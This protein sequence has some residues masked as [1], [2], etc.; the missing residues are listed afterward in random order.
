MKD[1]Y[2]IE[3]I[4]ADKLTHLLDLY[5]NAFG[6]KVS[7]EYFKK[8]FDT[9][10]FGA[11]YIGFI[12]YEDDGCPAAYYGLYPCKVELGGSE[13]L[14]ATSGDTMTHT[15][16]RGKGFFTRLAEHTYE[17]AKQSGIVFAFGFPNQNSLKGSVSLGWEYKGE[18]LRYYSFRTGA[19]PISRIAKKINL[20]ARI[21]G[22]K[23]D[24]NSFFPNSH[25]ID[26]AGGVIHDRNYFLY[27]NYSEKGIREFN[28]ARA[29]IKIDGALKVGDIEL[30]KDIE[31]KSCCRSIIQFAKRRGVPEVQFMTSAGT[32]L[33]RELSSLSKGMDAFPVGHFHFNTNG[34]DLSKMRYGMCDLD[35][36]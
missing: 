12:A 31:L 5:K 3:R 4:S 18:M 2:R 24:E 6:K 8:K 17:L 27:K 21:F 9:K 35:T 1:N 30:R 23:N 22:L 15:A 11:E 25:L 7:P 16:H 28:G 20:S 19:I 34:L 10:I 26:G 32:L 14:A 33:D 13:L 29:W 36:F